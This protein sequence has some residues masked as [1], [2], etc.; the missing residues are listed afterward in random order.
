[1]DGLDKTEVSLFDMNHKTNC[2]C[3]H[4]FVKVSALVSSSVLFSGVLTHVED[5]SIE[6]KEKVENLIRGT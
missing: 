6:A 4:H 5:I 3:F 1:M 2:S